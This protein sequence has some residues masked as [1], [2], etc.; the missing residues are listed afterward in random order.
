[1]QAVLATA[2]PVNELGLLVL[3]L[4]NQLAQ[5]P[6]GRVLLSEAPAAFDSHQPGLVNVPS[7]VAVSPLFTDR[8]LVPLW[9]ALG[10]LSARHLDSL[11]DF[12]R[13]GHGC[14]MASDEC[15]KEMTL[16]KV[17]GSW[18]RLCWIHD[19]ELADEAVIQEAALRN[20]ASFWLQVI[21][22][23]LRLSAGHPVS[24]PELCWWLTLNGWI[25]RLPE[26]ITRKVLGRPESAFQQIAL[27]L[28][29]TDD[30]Y[31]PEPSEQIQRL[32]QPVARFVADA[33]PPSLLML[34]PKPMRWLC[35]DYTRYVKALP[36]VVCQQQADDP[37]HL[38]GHG[39]GKMGGKAHDLFTIPL[40]RQHHDEL[41]RDAAGW[42]RRHGSQLQHLIATLDRALKEGALV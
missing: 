16:R 34:R 14:Q 38:I 12:V 22:G 5:A 31:L 7:V 28:T 3:K 25:D 10:E 37:H 17:G 32:A 1:M 19:H 20:Q 15:H 42:E 2:V 21:R 11:R 30:L 35:E 24:L 40:C 9:N 4:G 27:G 8:R 29:D 6:R 36:C 39:Q 33:E 41:H 18:V 23:G 26:S 13:R